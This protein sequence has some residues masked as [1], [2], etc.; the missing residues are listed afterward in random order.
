MEEHC[1]LCIPIS[2]NEDSRIRVLYET[3]LLDSLPEE[4]YDRYTTFAKRLFKT[5]IDLISLVDHQRV[6]FKSKTGLDTVQTHRNVAFCS[7]AI[8]EKR[9]ILVIPDTKLDKRFDNNPLV[10]GSAQLLFYAG[11]ALIIDNVKIGTLC[12]IDRKPRHFTENDEG[13]LIGLANIVRDFIIERRQSY[14]ENLSL[15]LA[16]VSRI[17]QPLKLPLETYQ[18]NYQQLVDI[19][20]ENTSKIQI[21][22]F[23]QHLEVLK[24]QMKQL[25]YINESVIEVLLMYSKLSS[26]IG[27][28]PKGNSFD[29]LLVFNEVEE[30]ESNRI[31]HLKNFFGKEITPSDLMKEVKELHFNEQHCPSCLTTT[32]LFPSNLDSSHTFPSYSSSSAIQWIL[33][34]ADFLSKPMYT[35]SSVLRL[36]LS[37]FT[38]LH[39][40]IEDKPEEQLKLKIIQSTMNKKDE[41][42]LTLMIVTPRPVAPPSSLKL[43]VSSVLAA[44]SNLH[45]LADKLL[46]SINKSSS[47][48]STSSILYEL[49]H[50]LDNLFT[51]P[52]S[53]YPASSSLLNSPAQSSFNLS[54]T[55]SDA[56]FSTRSNSR[57]AVYSMIPGISRFL[58]SSLIRNNDNND[59]HEYY[60]S[61][62]ESSS[63]RVH[64]HHHRNE[65]D[66]LHHVPEND[67]IVYELFIPYFLSHERNRLSLFN[68]IVQLSVKQ[69]SKESKLMN[70]DQ[71]NKRENKKLFAI[72]SSKSFQNGFQ[73]FF[74]TMFRTIF[75]QPAN[76]SQIHP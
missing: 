34:D 39:E 12:I 75:N 3:R 16:S 48:F 23:L 58:D 51:P 43:P 36:V 5:P 57:S 29:S 67:L 30:L 49:F 40:N 38:K 21:N 14:L 28:I 45:S 68:Q 18:A 46:P 25:S 53:S 37:I 19:S 35:Y 11:A 61:K 56:S 4:I 55:T 54:S 63:K 69:K 27:S 8:L 2:E 72:P 62:K 10:T 24:D 60:S 50:A 17:L 20:K 26:W 66:D 32:K 47:S 74:S 64:F 52:I 15:T 65:D 31:I 71:K 42:N 9:K 59:E 73:Q 70:K 6:W 7:Y 33:E 13:K 22:N 44:D 41:G 1:Q 76:F